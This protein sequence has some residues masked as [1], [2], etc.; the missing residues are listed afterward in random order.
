MDLAAK[1]QAVINTLELLKMP[2]SYENVNYL[3]GIYK[4]LAEV[5]D[6]LKNAE[7]ISFNIAPAAEEA[8]ERAKPDAE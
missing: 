7:D 4:T 3:M 6:A 2:A 5:R 1:L 8:E